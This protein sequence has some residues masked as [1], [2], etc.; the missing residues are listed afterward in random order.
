MNRVG[1]YVCVAVL[2]GDIDNNKIMNVVQVIADLICREFSSNASNDK[3]ACS[4]GGDL[5][6]N[7]RWN[8]ELS[9][10]PSNLKLSNVSLH[11]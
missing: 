3:V 11:L 8:M 6:C 2:E 7:M 4:S 5:V 10:I 1:G 9:L